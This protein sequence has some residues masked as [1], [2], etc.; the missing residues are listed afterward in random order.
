MSDWTGTGTHLLTENAMWDYLDIRYKDKWAGNLEIAN[1]I[2]ELFRHPITTISDL[3]ELEDKLHNV[4]LKAVQRNYSMEYLITTLYLAAL[5]DTVSTEIVREIKSDHPDQHLFS[6]SD[7]GNH[8]HSVIQNLAKHHAM[9][10]P[11]DQIVFNNYSLAKHFSGLSGELKD[12]Q[13]GGGVRNRQ[14]RGIDPKDSAKERCFCTFCHLQHRTSSCYKYNTA[15]ARIKRVKELH[16]DICYSCLYI[17]NKPCKTFTEP[18][19]CTFIVGKC[20][21]QFEHRRYLCLK[22][23]MNL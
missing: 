2:L 15:N 9:S 1:K 10:D 11:L 20:C 13:Q 19:I 12:S 7:L 21:G 23:G 17:H 5:P 16:P 3:V 18:S 22:L 4:Y 6:W 8:P 14:P